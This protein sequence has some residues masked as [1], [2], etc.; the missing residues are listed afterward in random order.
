METEDGDLLD[1]AFRTLPSD[2]MRL[3]SEYTPPGPVQGPQAKHTLACVVWLGYSRPYAVQ[4]VTA[5]IPVLD[6]KCDDEIGMLYNLF[7]VPSS[8]PHL[9]RCQPDK[10]YNEIAEYVCTLPRE[11]QA[12]HVMTHV[13]WWASS[14]K[15]SK[16]ENWFTIIRRACIPR[17]R[18]AEINDRLCVIS[19]TAVVAHEH[20]FRDTCAVGAQDILAWYRANVR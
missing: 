5:Q 3:I 13:V 6:G 17:I 10:L 15:K 1:V 11:P 4:C 20:T 9:F 19:P 2:L 8:P 16:A 12:E 18:A 14:G 7:A